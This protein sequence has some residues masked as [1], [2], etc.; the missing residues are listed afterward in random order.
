MLFSGEAV[1]TDENKPPELIDTNKLIMSN[2]KTNFNPPFK[3][4]AELAHR[5]I[6]R[7]N[8]VFLFMTDGDAKYPTEGIK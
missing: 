5:Y 3:K 4:T 6:D 1:V 7:Y 2:G 8:I